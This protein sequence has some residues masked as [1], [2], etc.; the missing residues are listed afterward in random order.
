MKNYN[1]KIRAFVCFKA[2]CLLCGFDS[3]NFVI[4]ILIFFSIKDEDDSNEW[5]SLN[6]DS[7]GSDED[8]D[9]PEMEDL[10]TED[11][12]EEGSISGSDEE[13]LEPSPPK[14][15]KSQKMG[16][17]SKSDD[18]QSL[19]ASADDFAALIGKSNF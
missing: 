10:E 15:K 19:L 9:K 1:L 13:E 3:N 12:D 18:L 14:K 16:K 11:F 6:E 5:E 4:K 17:K 7:D 8:A 2:T